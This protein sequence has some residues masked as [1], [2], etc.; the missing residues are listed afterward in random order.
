M[1]TLIILFF[2][3]LFI[4]A[5]MG[6]ILNF[7]GNLNFKKVSRNQQINHP[8]KEITQQNKLKTISYPKILKT[9]EDIQLYLDENSYRLKFEKGFPIYDMMKR[10]S[11]AGWNTDIVLYSK[12]RYGNYE[13]FLNCEDQEL[14]KRLYNIIHNYQ[15]HFDVKKLN[16]I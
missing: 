5:I 8:K 6:I 10:I 9:E 15:E 14:K 4:L 12:Y 3:L 13:Y 16:E 7:I 1:K 11:K 2:S